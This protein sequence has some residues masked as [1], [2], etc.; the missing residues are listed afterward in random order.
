MGWA[1]PRATS[2]GLYDLRASQYGAGTEKGRLSFG[3]ARR[4]LR[5]FDPGCLGLD[6]GQVLGRSVA[7]GSEVGVLIDDG[8]L[9]R[10]GGAGQDDQACDP[11]VGFS[12]PGRERSTEAVAQDEDPVGVHA[13]RTPQDLHG[14]QGVIDRFLL[15][16][17]VFRGG[18]LR[19]V[20]PRAFLIAQ[21]GDS[22]GG[23]APGEVAERLVRPNGLIAVVGSGT[24]DQD[25]G[26]ER[27]TPAGIVTV[28]CT[29]QSWVP[30]STSLSLKDA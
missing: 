5:V 24:M 12:D 14:G 26:G 4:E 3:V 30:N 29:I 28:P 22:A 8:V 21:H 13:F 10:P 17:E 7:D 16:R 1:R 23:Q 27:P 15:D 18:G 11:G 2:A 19:G 6:F 20:L 9:H 25:N